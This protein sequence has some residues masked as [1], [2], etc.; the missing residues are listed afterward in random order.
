NNNH[1]EMDKI[2]HIS[3]QDLE[4]YIKTWNV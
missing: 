4:E 3:K 2:D 1:A